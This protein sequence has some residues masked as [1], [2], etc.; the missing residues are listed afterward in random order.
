[1]E[2]EIE[3][4]N[5]ENKKTKNKKLLIILAIIILI[6]II[7]IICFISSFVN[8]YSQ[9]IVLGNEIENINK[10]GNVDT[11]IKS[12]G[13]YADVEKALKDY[14]TEYQTIATELENQYENDKFSTLLSAD[15]Y[16]SDGPEFAESKKLVSDIKGKG[17]EVKTKLSEMVTNEYKEKRASDMNLTGKYKD[18]FI[19]SIQIENELEKVNKTIDNINNYLE[20][21]ENIFDFLNE[22]NGKWEV[23]DNTVQ[24]Y[25]ATLLTKYNSLV[26]SV[27]IIANT[28]RM[29]L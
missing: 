1:M 3:S 28:L 27:N 25:D 15:N 23:K 24:F 20:K 4:T 17:E 11:E 26:S 9:R 19:E 2:E 18:L 5:S 6:G 12:K 10:T 22:N 29:G 13:K 21:V 7:G 14:I 16:A 8:E